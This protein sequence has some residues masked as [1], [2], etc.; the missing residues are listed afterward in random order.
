MSASS[1]VHTRGVSCEGCLAMA[2]LQLVPLTTQ[3]EVMPTLHAP[4]VVY[5]DQL[6][7]HWHVRLRRGASSFANPR[8]TLQLCRGTA[9]AV[10]GD[11]AGELLLCALAEKALPALLQLPSL[12]AVC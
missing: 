7:R 5:R 8:D 6:L 11:S 9:V 12:G 3:A 4:P 2:L 10:R 1:L